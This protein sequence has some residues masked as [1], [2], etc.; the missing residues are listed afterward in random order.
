MKT[1]LR[2][3]CILSLAAAAPAL[4]AADDALTLGIFPRYKATVTTTMFKPLADHLGERL[5]R[6]VTL[7]TAKD[8]DS[9]WKA[10][11]EQRYDIVHY[12]QYHYIHSAH[13]YT[14]IAH[15]QE[16][17]KDAVG[18]ALCGSSSRWWRRCARCCATR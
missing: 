4:R 3:L 18:G 5:H 8:F 16:F 15:Q 17:G 2:L 1:L 14:V 9:F 7:V 6:K 10:V 11:T 12:N 13:H